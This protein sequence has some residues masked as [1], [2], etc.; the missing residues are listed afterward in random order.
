MVVKC[1][2]LALVLLE[3]SGLDW[4]CLRRLH[5]SLPRAIY[6]KYATMSHYYKCNAWSAKNDKP[7]P[8]TQFTHTNIF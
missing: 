4:C 8:Y 6:R 2:G 3:V 1:I 5:A 7:Q